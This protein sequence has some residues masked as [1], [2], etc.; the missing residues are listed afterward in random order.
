[1]ALVNIH[2]DYI[3]FENEVLSTHTYPVRFF[4]ELL[5]YLRCKYGDSVLHALPREVATHLLDHAL[6]EA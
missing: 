6:V 1:M 3:Q 4:T 5:R 2:P